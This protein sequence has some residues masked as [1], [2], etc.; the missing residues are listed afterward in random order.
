ML[1]NGDI[2]SF[3]QHCTIINIIITF[4]YDDTTIIPMIFTV[5]YDE[6]QTLS[7]YVSYTDIKF[8]GYLHCTYIHALLLCVD[9]GRSIGL[10]DSSLHTGIMDYMH[11]TYLGHVVLYV[12]LRHLITRL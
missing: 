6:C 1:S 4:Y 7:N 5:Y 10:S 3:I 9:L 8:A 11:C 12:G 2:A